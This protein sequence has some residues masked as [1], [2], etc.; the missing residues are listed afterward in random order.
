MIKKLKPSWRGELEI[1]EAIQFLI[2]ENYKVDHRYVNGWW[3]DTGSPEDLLDANRLVLDELKPSIM[4]TV[5][6][7]RS[8]QGRVSIG[9]GSTIKRGTIVRGPVIVGENTFV[10]SHAYIGPYTSIGNNVNIMRGEIE[11]SIIMDG[12]FIDVHEKITDSLIGPNSRVVSGEGI[13]RGRKFII[14][15]SSSVNL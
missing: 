4:G 13:P 5:E 7:E 12:C 11:N 10:E 2:D 6:D 8:V 9:K 3:K 1:T 14:G 15:E